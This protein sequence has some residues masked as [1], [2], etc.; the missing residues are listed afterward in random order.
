LVPESRAFSRTAVEDVD[1][2]VRI[3]R[4][5][6]LAG[7]PR[8]DRSCEAELDVL[9]DASTD[10]WTSPPLPRSAIAAP[11]RSAATARSS[12]DSSRKASTGGP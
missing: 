11:A 4:E 1:D 9:D 7:D 12:V 10:Q 5:F 8:H 2:V 6:P 3:E